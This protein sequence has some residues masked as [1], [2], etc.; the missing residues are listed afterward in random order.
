MLWLCAGITVAQS[1]RD[2]AI[3]LPRI[4]YAADGLTATVTFSVSNSGGDAA[5]DSEILLRSTPDELLVFRL[6]LPRLAAG[7]SMDFS[8]EIALA[9]LPEDNQFFEVLAG[10][11][12]YEVADSP[13]A[14]NNRQLFRLELSRAGTG[15]AA[16]APD[17]EGGFLIPLLNLRVRSSPD[18]IEIGDT[19]MSYA[20]LQLAAVLALLVVLFLAVFLFLLRRILRRPARFQP[21]QPP[22]RM[23]HWQDPN[24]Q[25][26]RRQAWQFQAQN[27]C[28][29]S[30]R[31]HQQVAVIK[32][33]KNRAGEAFASW[34]VTQMRSSQYD[35]YGR[36]QRSE[37]LM[38]SKL[39]QQLTD[40]A[41]EAA[42]ADDSQLQPALTDLAQ[43]VSKRALAGIEKKHS[44]LPLVL[45]V[46]FTSAGDAQVAFE[47]YQCYN[48]AW[49]IVDAWAAE[50]GEHEPEPR[51]QF[52]FTLHGRRSGES[53]RDFKRRLP[54]DL[55][56]LFTRMLSHKEQQRAKAKITPAEPVISDTQP[57]ALPYDE[58]FFAPPSAQPDESPPIFEDTTDTKPRTN[59]PPATTDTRE[60]S[61]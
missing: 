39:C 19:R 25:L 32:H 52:T 34:T 20:S 33:L 50:L 14:R 29:D 45:D 36:I 8:Q 3:S 35:D 49:H 6:P 31:S 13:I 12:A 61:P 10:I 23:E 38:P 9:Q 53:Y 44:Q 22:Y 2:Y 57:L 37:T 46:Q 60:E 59:S 15:S 30:P 26:G 40:L 48:S 4:S 17:K 7:Q 18:G 47:L 43:R 11:D 27:N 21:W 16:P 51:E 42:T 54:Q 41:Q 55:Q 24:S 56:Q 58:Q 5:A 28:L 1:P